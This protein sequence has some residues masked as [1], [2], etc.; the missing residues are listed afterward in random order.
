MW[1]QFLGAALAGSTL[2][3]V[4]VNYTPQ[5]AAPAA[6]S[7]GGGGTGCR[8]QHDP[9]VTKLEES[10]CCKTSPTTHLIVNTKIE[11][12]PRSKGTG[13]KHPGVRR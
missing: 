9:Q 1:R 8:P 7:A 5:P 11:L 4:Q 13:T 3:S 12:P 6:M 2:I 10:E